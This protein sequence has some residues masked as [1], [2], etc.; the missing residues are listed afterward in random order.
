MQRPT[1]GGSQQHQTDH[2][3]AS[4]SSENSITYEENIIYEKLKNSG[5]LER[6]KELLKTRLHQNGW[7]DI[8][9]SAFRESMEERE[10][11]ELSV[12]SIV[13]DLLP[14]ARSKIPDSVKYEVVQQIQLFLEKDQDYSEL[15]STPPL[16]TTPKK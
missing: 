1:S 13:H 2:H 16:P 3:A 6:L 12:P 5:E 11:A 4:G 15:Y 14:I 10:L 8:I 9:S 7:N